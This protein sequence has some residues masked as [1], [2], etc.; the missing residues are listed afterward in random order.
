MKQL[1]SWVVHINA[2]YFHT[3]LSNISK[4]SVDG[5]VRI[6]FHCRLFI[7]VSNMYNSLGNMYIEIYRV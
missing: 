5:E 6:E 7:K 1:I 3:K 2:S 4:C